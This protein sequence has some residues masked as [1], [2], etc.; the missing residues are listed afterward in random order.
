MAHYAQLEATPDPDLLVVVQNIVAEADF[1]AT[2]AVGD[3]ASW[4]QNSYNTRGGVHYGPDGAPDGGQALRGNFAG[5]G[6]LYSKQ[7][8]IFFAPQPYPSWTLDVPTAS[9]LAPVAY[10][11]DGNRYRWDESTT[12]WVVQE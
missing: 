2:G 1:I 3:P 9:W 10:P 4:L 5:I 11:T 8:D 12:S 7:H 6:Y